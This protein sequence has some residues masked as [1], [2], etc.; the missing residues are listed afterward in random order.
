[1]GSYVP[2]TP[3]QQLDML[4][5]IGLESFDELFA[6]VPRSVRLT[7]PLNIP[8]GRSELEVMAHMEE[9]AGENRVFSHIF[10]GA[11]AYRHYIPAIVPAVV[12]K[13]EFVTAYTPYQAEIS[14]G[15]LQSIFEYQTMICQL[16]GMDASNA[17]VYDGATAAA[18]AAAMCRDRKHRTVYVSQAAPPQVIEVI[19]T[20]CFSSG[21]EL[22]VIPHQDGITDL[23][24][25]EHAL[26]DDPSPA[27]L[28][29]QQPNYFGC[30]E[31]AEA[32]GEIAH[33][34]GAK[35]IMGC[36]PISLG[37]LKSPGEWG[38]DIAV[39]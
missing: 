12:S 38:A 4:R 20:Y 14:Q 8:P 6:D 37:L 28:Y 15:L 18:E 2:N 11:G 24:A 9:L 1:M 25:L 29:I 35:F 10:R 26:K 33:K 22:A 23:S 13:E 30:L 5:S 19:R 21:A 3:E 16:T 32:L 27:C 17:S 36:N 31:P 34:A 39:G 7:Q